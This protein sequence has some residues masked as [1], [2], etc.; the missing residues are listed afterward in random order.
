MSRMSLAALAVAAS[1]L[2]ACAGMFPPNAADVAKVPVVRYGDAAPDGKE[3][4]LHYPAGARLPL[5]A[6][7]GGTLLV[8]PAQAT[9]EVA[10]NRDVY[11]YRGWVSFDGK[12]W[13]AGNDAV[14]A[15]F[16]IELPG[17]KDTKSPGAM[18]ARFDVK[19]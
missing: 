4:I 13:K 14:D 6:S 10:T 1:T 12:T 16:L 7:V 19:P 5:V 9:L 18:S 11:V 17:E 15:E 8:S 3:Y 2:G